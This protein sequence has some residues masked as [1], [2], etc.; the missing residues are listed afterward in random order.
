MLLD[1][2]FSYLHK[3]VYL[4]RWEE[5]A[6]KMP[7]RKEQRM[8]SHVHVKKSLPWLSGTSVYYKSKLPHQKGTE[9]LT[10][11]KNQKESKK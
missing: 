4:H 2:L 3:K 1:Q 7:F 5:I 11:R 9:N 6:P 10:A 8:K